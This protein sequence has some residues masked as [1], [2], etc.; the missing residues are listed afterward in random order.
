MRAPGALGEA[1]PH[2]PQSSSVFA[3][4]SACERGS[5]REE[6]RVLVAEVVLGRTPGLRTNGG[7]W[8]LGGRH[9]Q[10]HV[11]MWVKVEDVMLS[12]KR[13]LLKGRHL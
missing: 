10:V 4:C 6:T 1:G 2:V 3:A 5:S 9:C 11:L 7:G 8:G 12:E 13:K